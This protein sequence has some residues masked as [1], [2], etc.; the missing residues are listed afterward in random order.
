MSEAISHSVSHSISHL[1]DVCQSIPLSYFHVYYLHRCCCPQ[2]NGLPVQAGNVKDLK[3]QLDSC[4]RK[5]DLKLTVQS[6]KSMLGQ[7]DAGRSTATSSQR[8]SSLPFQMQG[9]DPALQTQR[10]QTERDESH[11]A[12]VSL[13]VSP[14][15]PIA[16]NET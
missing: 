7:A 11:P 15:T 9:S 2:I 3:K 1:L 16:F 4:L 14:A 13:A 8:P 10:K 5:G 12:K 6:P